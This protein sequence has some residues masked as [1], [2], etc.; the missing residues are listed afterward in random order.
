[1]TTGSSIDILSRVKQLLPGRW[2]KWTAPY[3]DAVLGG[4]SDLSAWCYSLIGYARAQTRLASAY[5]IWLDILA[6]DFLGRTLM[7]NGAPDDAFRAIVK[8]TI[9]QER[10]TRSGMIAAVTQLTGIPPWVFEPWNT[11][12]TG[13]Y[14]GGSFKC[15]QFGYGVGRGGYGNMGLPAQTFMVVTRTAP[16]GIPYVDGYGNS[17]AGYGKGAIEY[18]GNNLALSGV[19]NA[20]INQLV[21]LTKPTGSTVWL[22]IGP[23]PNPQPKRPMIFNSKPDSQNLAII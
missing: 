10:V 13:A 11:Y 1:M 4:L 21:N 6:Y 8:A 16:S 19:T 7:R 22:N 9:L 15:G 3:R 2:F 5:G 14:S 18:A 12:D 17:V 20:M 23:Q